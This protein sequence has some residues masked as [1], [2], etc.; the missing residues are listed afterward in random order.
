MADLSRLKSQLAVSGLSGQNNALWQVINQLIDASV[1]TETTIQKTVTVLSGLTFLPGSILFADGAGNVS[2]DSPNLFWDDTNKRVGIGTNTPV[3]PLDILRSGLAAV[4]TDGALLENRTLATGAVL[5]QMSP[6]LRF[7][8]SAWDGA[9]PKAVDAFIELLPQSGTPRGL[10]NIGATV[11]GIGTY[12]PVQMGLNPTTNGCQFTLGGGTPGIGLSSTIRGG[13]GTVS[14]PVFGFINSGGGGPIGF[15]SPAP[16]DMNLVCGALNQILWGTGLWRNGSALSITWSSNVDP[17]LAVGDVAFTRIG[18]GKLRVWNNPEAS[19]AITTAGFLIDMQTDAVAKFRD[20]A[21]AAFATVDCLD[22]KT[23]NA[24]FMHRTGVA[25]TNNA[26]AAVGTLN[27]APAAGDPTK[28]IR[29]D[30]N[31][32][33]RFIPAW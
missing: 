16:N 12:Y 31:G 21:D 3:A 30:D 4:S 28:W 11:Q 13:D 32:T 19:G 20:R 22:I 29:I 18:Q 1:S 25:L 23:E 27:N 15:W 5:A 14:L 7:R 9:L 8:G 17:N 10:L 6:R 2:S 33:A 26:A 24:T